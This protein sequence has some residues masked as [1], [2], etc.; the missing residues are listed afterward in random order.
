MLGNIVYEKNIKNQQTQQIDL[1]WLADGMY[2]IKIQT[3]QQS[4]SQKIIIQR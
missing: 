4:F 3:P 2:Y 1:S